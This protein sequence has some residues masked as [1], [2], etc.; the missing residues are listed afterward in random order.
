VRADEAIAAPLVPSHYD[1]VPDTLFGG[2]LLPPKP[3]VGF[4]RDVDWLASH[5]TMHPN[6]RLMGIST[7]VATVRYHFHVKVTL[8]M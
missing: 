1:V 8:M 7:Q 3:I 6:Q 5:M 4:A 2:L